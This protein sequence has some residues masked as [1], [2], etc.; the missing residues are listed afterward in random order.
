VVRQDGGED[1]RLARQ[2]AEGHGVPV[3]ELVSDYDGA[4]SRFC[5]KGGEPGEAASPGFAESGEGALVRHTSGTT[6]RPK[7]VPLLHKNVAAS[8]RNIREVL[9]LS[10]DDICLSI[11]PLFH[12]HGLIAGSLAQLSAGGQV[13]VPGPF[14]ALAMLRGLKESGATW[15]N[16]V[17]T[18]H[19][20]LMDRPE[21]AQAVA[22]AL[23][24]KKLGE[25]VAVMR[26][27]WPAETG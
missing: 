25:T 23:P 22:F 17:P 6:S 10:A 5:L 20:A 27:L 14:N 19:Q 16:G 15:Y 18:M 7:I 13:Y 12:I 21:V 24:H 11:M 9:Q 3:L 26:Q 4:A 2:A 1:A 8:A